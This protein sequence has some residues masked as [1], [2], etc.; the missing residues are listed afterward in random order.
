MSRT[1]LKTGRS[2]RLCVG[3]FTLEF[4]GK[5]ETNRTEGGDAINQSQ[6]PL[7]PMWRVSFSDVEDALES[8]SSAAS[9]PVCSRFFDST[10]SHNKGRRVLEAGDVGEGGGV[11]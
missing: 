3:V 4:G 7:C 5:T 9:I 8:Q 11:S 1:R 6:V 10:H 2:S